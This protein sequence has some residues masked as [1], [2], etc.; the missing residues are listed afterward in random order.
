MMNRLNRLYVV[1]SELKN[2]S[3]VIFY[4]LLLIAKNE[5]LKNSF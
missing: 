4:D 3:S 1:K 2:S 5:T